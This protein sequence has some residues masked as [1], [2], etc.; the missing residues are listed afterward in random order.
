MSTPA[1]TPKAGQAVKDSKSSVTKLGTAKKSACPCR[2][3]SNGRDWTVKCFTCSQAWHLSC[4]NLKGLNVLKD[5]SKVNQ[6][7]SQW[8]CP[9][10]FL[11]PYPPPAN[12]ESTKLK[13]NLQL[14]VETCKQNA[15]TEEVVVDSL[16]QQLPDNDTHLRTINLLGELHEEVSKLQELREEG[17]NNLKHLQHEVTRLQTIRSDL[18]KPVMSHSPEVTEH[19]A[20]QEESQESLT[21]LETNPTRHIADYVEDFID[22]ETNDTLVKFCSAQKYTKYKTG[23][24]ACT[25]GEK[26]EFNGA[27]RNNIKDVPA[28]LKVLIEKIHKHENMC[29]A[30]DDINQVIINRYTGGNSSLPEHSDD[31]S[32]IAPGSQIFTLSLGCTRTMKFRDLVGN[33]EVERDVADCS[34]YVM[35]KSSQYYWTHRM[36]KTGN[37]ATQDIRYSITFRTVGERF[38]NASVVIGDSNTK[39]LNFSTGRKGEVGTFGYTIPGKRILAYH[40]GEIN[41]SDCIGYQNAVIHCGINNLREGSPGRKD[42]DPDASNVE[43]NFELLKDK[44]IAIKKLCPY[45]SITVSPVLP[46]K[47]HKLNARGRQFNSLLFKFEEIHPIGKKIRCLDFNEFV[48]FNNGLLKENLGVWDRNTKQHNRKDALHLGREGIRVLA[49]LVRQSILGCSKVNGRLYSDVTK[50]GRSSVNNR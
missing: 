37:E 3:S 28:A 43:G 27:P 41:P 16:S 32:S 22:S 42:N 35:S 34:L 38:K 9:W 40:I 21:D 49:G 4:A 17:F 50:G 46:T 30:G 24:E 11:T 15:D 23:R 36:D 20:P 19:L 26:Y 44:I 8:L 33:T 1:S 18:F 13:D 5:E 29:S 7:L 2:M 31:E 6:M 45:T 14:N 39:Y 25:F 12:S 48:D 10:C 47:S